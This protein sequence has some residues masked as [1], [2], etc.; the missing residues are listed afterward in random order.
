MTNSNFE[1]GGQLFTFEKNKEN[2]QLRLKRSDIA[3]QDML[4]LKVLELKH[5]L[6]LSQ[7]MESDDDT[8]VFTYQIDP[9]SYTMAEVQTW[10]EAEKLRVALNVLALSEALKLPLTFLLHPENLFITKDACVQIA[11]RGV[12]GLMMPLEMTE[13]DFLRQAKCL[14]VTLFVETDYMELYNGSLEVVKLPAFLEEV[15]QMENVSDLEELIRKTYRDR[16]DE[17]RL[18][19]TT[20]PKS[21][22]KWFKLGTIWFGAATFL[23][24]I[25][26]IYLVFIQYPFKEKMLDADTAFIKVDYAGV[27]RKLEKV[28]LND[29]PYTQKYELAYS[30]AR[31]LSHEFSK[32]QENVIFNNL[33]LK[34]EELYLDYWI[35]IGRGHGDEAIDIAKRLDDM[36]LILYALI[37]KQE[38]VREDKELSGE[39]REEKLSELESEYKKY[40][41]QR[42]TLLAPAENGEEATTSTGTSKP[43]ESKKEK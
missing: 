22:L 19:Q 20:V 34:S 21:Q 42:D 13:E 1:W 12:P 8:I 25:P 29:L 16:R 9:D 28:E 26:L 6:F 5:P 14:I 38:Q 23:L 35:E 15:R 40:K 36:D 4:Q 3:T 18:R 2:W 32:E 31:S 30:Y 43:T 10:S 33:T 37:E 24:L 27:I 11:Y 41:D 7:T 39:K 17:E